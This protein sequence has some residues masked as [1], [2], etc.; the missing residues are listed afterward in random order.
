MQRPCESPVVLNAT[1]T[2]PNLV[3]DWLKNN[4]V[5]PP[6]GP[7][8]TLSAVDDNATFQVRVT[9]NLS[10]CSALMVPGKTVRIIEPFTVDIVPPVPACEGSTFD[11]TVTP[12]RTDVTQFQWFL[13][14]AALSD[15][16]NTLSENRGGVYKVIGILEGCQSPPD[17]EPIGLS[18][19]PTVDLGPL[20][21]IC[22]FPDIIPDPNLNQASL[23]PGTGFT[24]YQWFKVNGNVLEDQLVT[25]P[26]FSAVEAG[27]YRVLVTDNIGCQNFDEVEVI[28]ECDPIITGPNAFRPGSAVNG[29]NPDRDNGQFWV[30]S[31]FITDEDFRVLIFN[32]WGQMV[33][34]SDD[35]NFLWNGGMNGNSGQGLPPGTY[36][37]VIRY[38]SQYF[39]EQGIKEKRGGVVLIR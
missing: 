18:P 37:Y 12:S 7:S 3:H 13:N 10:Q 2:G 21:R 33:F 30:I 32:R 20:K 14:D 17:E 6:S 28:E 39:P 38:K 35:R 16:D 25:D 24:A 8:Y 31:H 15:T 29:G 27:T 5:V 26:I 9:N 19:K 22:P 23:T 36:A 4:V 34:E 1:Q 11:I